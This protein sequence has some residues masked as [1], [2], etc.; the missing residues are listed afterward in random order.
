MQLSFL[1]IMNF[2]FK[3]DG[4]DNVLIYLVLF[5]SMKQVFRSLAI[6]GV[7]YLSTISMNF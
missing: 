1:K 6:Y 7:A 5:V 3:F 4:I 2:F